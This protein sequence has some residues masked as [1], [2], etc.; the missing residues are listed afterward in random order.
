MKESKN[1]IEI[2]DNKYK[3]Y[4]EEDGKWLNE[5]FRNIFIEGE[6]SRKN[7]KTSVY[8]MLPEEIREDVDQLLSDN[9]S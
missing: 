2:L 6:A 5:G 9:F 1:I 8:L 4:L 3:A 7:L